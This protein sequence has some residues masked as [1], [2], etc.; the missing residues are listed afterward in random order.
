MFTF[1]NH[2]RV[3]VI[4][5]MVATLS[6]AAGAAPAATAEPG[7]TADEIVVGQ[8]LALTGPIADLSREIQTGV[9]AYV[10]SLNRAGGIHGRR[11][12][13]VTLDDGYQ[14]PNTVKNVEQLIKQDKVFALL[15]VTGTPHCEAILPM[16]RTLGVPLF[17]PFTGADSLR[18]P[19]VPNVF[20]VRAGYRA[21]TE[22]LVR[23]LHTV[24]IKRIGVL[25]QGS[26]FGADGLAGV[27]SAMQALD[28]KPVAEVVIKADGSDTADAVAKMA[29]A[30][31][32]A[33]ILIT[34]GRPT[35]SFIQQFNKAGGKG[36]QFYTLSVMGTAANIKA[37]GADGIGVVVAAVMPFPWSDAN[38]LVKEYQTAMRAIGQNEFSF[39]SLESYVNAKLLAEALRRAGPDLTRQRLI[40]AAE[41]L[42]GLDV[43][44]MRVGFSKTSRQAFKYVEL[45]IIGGNGKFIR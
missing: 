6:G 33:V 42:G 8:S 13:V 4:F 36:V 43:G 17:S 16:V 1:L 30:K 9:N 34:A 35:F 5:A 41:G 45:V 19:V 10:E 31:P 24:S 38:P 21:E 26:S 22:R 3:A 23:H 27:R 12:K 7:V 14:V 11:L 44:G 40:A 37:L 25:Y 20:N 39:V 29:E 2:K 15:N 32:D 28:I 18:N